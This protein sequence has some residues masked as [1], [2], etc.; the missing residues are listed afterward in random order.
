M[1]YKHFRCASKSVTSPPAQSN[2]NAPISL[3]TQMLCTTPWLNLSVMKCSLTD[4]S[5]KP[6]WSGLPGYGPRNL[7]SIGK[8]GSCQN[9]AYLWSWRLFHN[10]KTQNSTGC[11]S[12][13]ASIDGLAVSFSFFLCYRED[14]RKKTTILLT[15]FIIYP[16]PWNLFGR[17]QASWG[18]LVFKLVHCRDLWNWNETLCF[19]HHFFLANGCLN[20]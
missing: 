8:G 1:V 5:L 19:P 2:T 12:L 13:A 9:P 11:T 20:M 18:Y 7:S 6:S 15:P 3:A 4:P 17:P 14:W 10:D 16:G